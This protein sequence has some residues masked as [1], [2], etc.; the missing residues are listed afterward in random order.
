MT[1]RPR[2][3]IVVALIAGSTLVPMATNADTGATTA[4]PPIA[5]QVLGISSERPPEVAPFDRIGASL[6]RAKRDGGSGMIALHD[7]PTANE[8]QV[9]AEGG[10]AMPTGDLDGDGL[11]DLLTWEWARD[12]HL[13]ARKGSTGA[14]LWRIIAPE[15]QGSMLGGPLSAYA[16]LAIDDADGDGRNDL[17]MVTVVWDSGRD[18]VAS[19]DQRITQYDGATGA[20]T[21]SWSETARLVRATAASERAEV[22]A[23]LA[24]GMGMVAD[25]TGDGVAD[26]FV[27]LCSSGGNPKIAGGSVTISFMQSCTAMHFDRHTGTVATS[28]HPWWRPTLIESVGDL[29]GDGLGDVVVAEDYTWFTDVQ[30][31]SATGD[32][33]AGTSTRSHDYLYAFGISLRGRTGADL[34][35]VGL[36][37]SPD[38]AFER[39]AVYAFGGDTG[40]LLWARDLPGFGGM[41]LID[42][43][44]GDG[45]HD[46][47]T[48]NASPDAARVRAYDGATFRKRLWARTVAVETLPGMTQYVGVGTLGDLDGDGVDDV[49]MW[50]YASSV[51]EYDNQGQH[52]MSG[53]TGAPLWSI[54][55]LQEDSA[56]PLRADM[57]GDGKMD[58]ARQRRTGNAWTIDVLRGD[59]LAHLWTTTPITGVFYGSAF[60][61]DVV[62]ASGRELITQVADVESDKIA[63]ESSTGRL[64]SLRYR[65]RF[66]E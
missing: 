61:A 30:I 56:E 33:L 6:T 15:Y 31:Y 13:V 65:D 53:R 47:I 57:D 11:D 16:W 5:A 54:L 59:T 2:H 58:V 51:M 10:W 18:G 64:W 43:I 48:G 14:E 39:Y 3:L 49:T 36:D 38:H 37:L 32:F 28:F 7:L 34:V 27:T 40:D 19:I 50:P 26:P 60:A 29:D 21:W 42:D 44:D 9:D 46:L 45:G 25:V 62:A 22:Y 4:R 41:S 35:M 12:D 17:T 52:T 66:G 8:T 1:M 23:N 20:Q 24:V 63:A 55:D